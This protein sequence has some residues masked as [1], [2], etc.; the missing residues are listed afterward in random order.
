MA[1]DNNL[2]DY[3]TECALI[4]SAMIR[5]P[6]IFEE[7]AVTKIKPRHFF[8]DRTRDTWRVVIEHRDKFDVVAV[9]AWLKAIT[10][11]ADSIWLQSCITHCEQ[12]YNASLYAQIIWDFS[13][14]RW[15]RNAISKLGA[16]LFKDTSSFNTQL[17]ETIKTL[18]T[19][20]EAT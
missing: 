7:P 19:I 17:V 18:T 13:R 11:H 9:A 12:S 16:S 1:N 3:D 20:K 5:G 6:E 15:A 8:D 2:H 14:K 4:G 10:E